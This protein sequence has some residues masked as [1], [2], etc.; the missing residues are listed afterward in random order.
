M[1]QVIHFSV[2]I[3]LNPNPYSEYPLTFGSWAKNLCIINWSP[4]DGKSFPSRGW[5]LICNDYFWLFS[6]GRI[7]KHIFL[8]SKL[9]KN[10]YTYISV[11]FYQLNTFTFS[12]SWICK[13]KIWRFWPFF[14]YYFNHID[15]TLLYW[16]FFLQIISLK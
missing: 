2:R 9:K 12:K 15:S 5:Q 6:I 16:R 13:M 4:C 7:Y 11:F 14:R 1:L 10:N 8:N 3:G